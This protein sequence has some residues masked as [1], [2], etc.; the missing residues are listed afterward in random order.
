MHQRLLDVLRHR[1][2]VGQPGGEDPPVVATPF[3][4]D[5][6]ISDLRHVY[7]VDRFRRAL[8][9]TRPP[10][11]PSD[12]WR[13]QKRHVRTKLL[14]YKPGRRAVF[15]V[16][17]GMRSLER[18]EKVRAYWHVKIVTPTAVDPTF[19]NQKAI[20]DALP[21][22]ADWRV[23][24]PRGTVPSRTRHAETFQKLTGASSAVARGSRRDHSS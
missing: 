20:H 2:L 9:A 1:D 19:E 21:A 3:P 12:K 16:R 18:N 23:P 24:A 10:E 14:A 17:V 15:K 6:E 7:D 22:D 5:P 11:L 8:S 13:L 4:N